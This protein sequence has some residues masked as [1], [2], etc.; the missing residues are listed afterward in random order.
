VSHFDLHS[1]KNCLLIYLIST[2][3]D[4][5]MTIRYLVITFQLLIHYLTFWPW[6]LTFRS[7]SVTPPIL[8]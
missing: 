7:W 5:D 6:P 1:D 3:P 4:V 8:I 2:K